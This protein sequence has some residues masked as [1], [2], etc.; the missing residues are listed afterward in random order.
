MSTR[1][2]VLHEWT[3]Q[4]QSLLPTVH[5]TRAATLALFSLGMLWS[6]T[7]TLLKVA[8]ALPLAACDPSTERRLR[9][10]L[11]NP[12]VT[13]ATLWQPLLPVLLAALGQPEVLFVFDPTPY[14]DDATILCLGV[15]WRGRVLP[16]A[17]RVVPQQSD[18]PERLRPLLDALLA[19][20]A[21]AL[22]PGCTPTLLAD[23]GLVGPA[24]I[25]AAQ[26]AGWHVIL[27]LK[28]S[29]GEETRVRWPEGREQRLAELPTGPGQRFA[30]PAAIFKAAGWRQGYLTIHWARAEEE[31]WVLF[32]DRPAGPA[33][34]RE[35]RRRATAEATYE[36]AKGR[37]FKLEGS[38]VVAL[39]RIERLLLVLHL[40]LWWA[41]A[42]GVQTIRQGWR[43]RYD[44]PDRRDLSVVR[45]GIT[46]GRDALNQDHPHALPF[47]RTPAGWVYPWPA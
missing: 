45:L 27:R 22:P 2:Q 4:V 7:V 25:D 35:Y 18:W 46:A 41:F 39:A 20:V 1:M 42:L 31:P 15:V 24:I 33:R 19:A 3:R 13:V 34:V 14:R 21:A 44:R 10:F 9:R 47:R 28:A 26:A 11:A 43:R 5:A 8:A 12:R 32:S 23:R 37:G 40:A 16:V 30:A 29:A 38:K 6:G 17:W 36:D